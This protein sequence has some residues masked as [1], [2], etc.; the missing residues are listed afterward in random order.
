MKY[1]LILLVLLF[2]CAHSG[3]PPPSVCDRPEAAESVICAACSEIGVPV[4]D[5][6]LL[7]AIVALRALDNYERATVLKFYIDVEDFLKVTSSYIEL[8]AFVQKY[9]DVTG[10][11]ILIISRYLPYFNSP[12]LVGDF[13]RGLLLFHIEKM[14]AQLVE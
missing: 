6:D 11:E 2:G 4:E 7:I 5:V 12:Q 10:P 13:D 8:I 1:S 3:P 9:I 14:K